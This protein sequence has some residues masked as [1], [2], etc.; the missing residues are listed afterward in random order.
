ML[1]IAIRIAQ[2]MGIHSEAVL[3]KC[4]ALE[5]EMRRRLWWSLILFDTRI[6]EMSDYKAT[7][8]APSWD[9]RIPLNVNDSDLR[10]EMKDLPVVQG[11]STEALFIVVRSEVAEFIRNS[12]FYLEFTNPALKPI[13]KDIHHGPIPEGGEAVALEKMIEDKY[14]KFCDPE[15]ML[16]FMTIWMTRSYLAK[17]RLVEHYSVYYNSSV[18][19]TEAQCDA[20]ISY[21]LRMLECDTKLMASPLTKRFFWLNQLYFPMPAYIQIVQDLRRRPVSKLAEQS[22]E[23]MSTNY[24]AR[25]DALYGDGSPFFRVFAKLILQAWEGREAVLR[26]SDEPFMLPTVVSRIREQA[27]QMGEKTQHSDTEQPDSI[28][29][30]GVDNFWLSM[31]MN[32]DSHPIL[33]RLG[34]PDGYVG[35]E[36]GVYPNMPGQAPLEVDV[37]GLDWSAMDW[38]LMNAPSGYTAGSTDPSRPY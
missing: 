33:S 21:A 17:C 27:T 28:M 11:T 6:C 25:F 9:C 24:E 16:H 23:V 38:S 31:P 3:A 37:N 1:A 8:L 19:Q 30:M 7:M 2:R 12:M 29:S 5:A 35:T 14:L 15:N 32:F 36:M 20:G 26:Q 22:W 10:L 13:A 34:G 18:H 4:T